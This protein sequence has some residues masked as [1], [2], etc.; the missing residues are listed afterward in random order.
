[1]SK[2]IVECSAGL[3]RAE[4]DIFEALARKGW[5]G[6]G[7]DELLE[8]GKDFFANE[9]DSDAHPNHGAKIFSILPQNR[10]ILAH[11][12]GDGLGPHRPAH[13]RSDSL[14]VDGLPYQ[15]LAGAM[16]GRDT[17]VNSIFSERDVST[18]ILNRPRG[19]RP[20]SPTPGESVEDPLNNIV[21]TAPA[22]V[23]SLLISKHMP[24]GED[25]EA[26]AEDESVSTK[27]VIP[28]FTTLES[29][30]TP[31]EEESGEVTPKFGDSDTPIR[32]VEREPSQELERESGL[33]APQSEAGYGAPSEAGSGFGAPSE[34]GTTTRTHSQSGERGERRWSVTDDG[35]VSN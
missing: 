5:N 15:S 31:V 32:S 3:V 1:M 23:M 30:M 21:V 17:D 27:T 19:V 34:A 18:G 26:N 28:I 11:D 25:R 9:T 14:L 12:A 6:G 29:P 13:G 8:K 7:L 16:S 35:L 2:G 24:E 10:S 20:F 33:G 4:V 22:P